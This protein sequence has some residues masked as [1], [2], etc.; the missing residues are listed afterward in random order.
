MHMLLFSESS[1][2]K[3]GESNRLTVVFNAKPAGMR[4]FLVC[5]E[6]EGARAGAPRGAGGSP[7]YHFTCW[8]AQR[9]QSADGRTVIFLARSH[10]ID[11]AGGTSILTSNG[12]ERK[13]KLPG[14]SVERPNR[15]IS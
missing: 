8:T 11:G 7:N 3:F 6:E 5:V 2:A 1:K 12:D 10:T 4:D 9:H 14:G 13:K 15:P